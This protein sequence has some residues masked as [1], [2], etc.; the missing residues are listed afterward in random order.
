VVRDER[1]AK[2]AWVVR[3]YFNPVPWVERWG[4]TD[5]PAD[6]PEFAV[7]RLDRTLSEYLN[8]VLDAGFH[9]TRIEEPRPSEEY[10]RSTAAPLGDDAPHVAGPASRR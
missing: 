7:P 4:F 3:N 9:L 10:C 6:A 8:A 2:L 5:A 1:G